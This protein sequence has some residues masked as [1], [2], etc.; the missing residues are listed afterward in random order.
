MECVE[1][2]YFDSIADRC[3]LRGE[4]AYEESEDIEDCGN[5]TLSTQWRCEKIGSCIMMLR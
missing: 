1:C 3:A 5:Y 2:I 4:C